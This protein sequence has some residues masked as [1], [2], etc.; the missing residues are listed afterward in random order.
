LQGVIGN[1]AVIAR[2][3]SATGWSLQGGHRYRRGH[4]NVW[5]HRGVA[6]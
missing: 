5:W 1:R 4:G 3:S 6:L 2:R